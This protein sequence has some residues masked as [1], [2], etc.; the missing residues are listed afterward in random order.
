M[1]KVVQLKINVRQLIWV[2]VFGIDLKLFL[3]GIVQSQVH[4]VSELGQEVFGLEI[5]GKV[6]DTFLLVVETDPYLLAV[7]HDLQ[8][9]QLGQGVLGLYPSL[10]HLVYTLNSLIDLK[11]GVADWLSGS[12]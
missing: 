3:Y 1:G 11:G 4:F 12:L 9:L 6:C 5:V 8:N 10:Y 7:L 2:R